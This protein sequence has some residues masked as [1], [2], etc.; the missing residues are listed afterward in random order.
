MQVIT[1]GRYPK[2]GESIQGKMIDQVLMAAR[3]GYAFVLSKNEVLLVR[4][5]DEV[6]YVGSSEKAYYVMELPNPPEVGE[7][8]ETSRYCIIGPMEKQRVTTGTIEK[9]VE[10][11]PGHLWYAESRSSAYYV[12]LR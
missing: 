11:W 7:R 12:V 10:V 3:T 8:Y 9:V 4:A 5:I 6:I 1:V 2:E